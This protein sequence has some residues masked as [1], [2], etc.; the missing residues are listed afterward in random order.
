MSF[1][2]LFNLP[3]STTP[4]ETE[5][6]QPV[7]A[8]T[9]VA[10]ETEAKSE[11]KQAV[12][13]EQPKVES[14]PERT[15]V[16]NGFTQE[17]LVQINQAFNTEFERNPINAITVAV[18][19]GFTLSL[20]EEQ[21]QLLNQVLLEWEDRD[22]F[23]AR[24]WFQKMDRL[25]QEAITKQSEQERLTQLEKDEKAI[26]EKSEAIQAIIQENPYFKDEEAQNFLHLLAEYLEDIEGDTPT[27]SK[28]EYYHN[29]AK[30]IHMVVEKAEKRGYEKAKQEQ[31][32]KKNAHVIGSGNTI[33]AR[34]KKNEYDEA[35][36]NNDV[37]TMLGISLRNLKRT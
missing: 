19:S 4:V 15:E 17:E 30:Q 33:P 2:N 37:D 3:E 13:T 11:P 1:D 34:T 25:Q 8:E 35:L 32:K 26:L 16:Y 21:K 23:E 28:Q 12:K 7:E 14:Q 6:P 22:A 20:S 24:S 29:A 18:E 36:Q 27:Q 9:P 31:V 5:S 10:I